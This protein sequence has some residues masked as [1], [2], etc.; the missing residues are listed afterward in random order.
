MWTNE[1]ISN[2][3]GKVAFITGAN[4]G[5]GLETARALYQAGAKVILASRDAAKAQAALQEIEQSGGEGSLEI[6]VLDLTSLEAVRVCAEQFRQRHAQLDI[7]INNA[8]VMTPPASQTAEGYELQFGVNFLGHFALTGYLYPLLQATPGSRVVTVTSLAYQ[9]GHL[10]FENLRLEKPYDAAREYSQSKLADL[11]FTQ[12]LQQRIEA[13]GDAILSLAAHPGVT[14]SQ[15][16]RYMSPKAYQQA[17]DR[18]GELM[19]PVQGA[20]PSLYAA[21]AP[22]VVPGGFYGPDQ[23]GGLRGY[24]ILTA[25]QANVRDPEVAKTLWEKAESSTGLVYP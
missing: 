21:V 9:S 11:L 15:L 16:S 14:Q 20:L 13:K 23:D 7:L 22:D 25:I 6:A 17:V 10:D 1:Q 4:S 2:Q 19:P 12:A 3:S 24:P 18:F 5:I 8:G